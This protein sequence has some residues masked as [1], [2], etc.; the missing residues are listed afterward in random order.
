MNTKFY[1]S[2]FRDIKKS[3]KKLIIFEIIIMLLFSVLCYY[4]DNDYIK[5]VSLFY[6]LISLFKIFFLHDLSI[7][8]YYYEYYLETGRDLYQD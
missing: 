7:Y 4:A 1:S 8:A 6:T 5:C 2:R 3:T